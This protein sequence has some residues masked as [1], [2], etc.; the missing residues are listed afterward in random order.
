VNYKNNGWPVKGRKIT[1]E[2]CNSTPH[3]LKAG[4]RQLNQVSQIEEK[5]F[6]LEAHGGT[7]SP[8]KKGHT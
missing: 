8:Y 4:S 6:D 2:M 7:R 1:G 5:N 3:A